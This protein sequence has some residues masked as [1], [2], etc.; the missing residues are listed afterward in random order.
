MKKQELILKVTFLDEQVQY[1]SL[2]VVGEK[3][4]V[5]DKNGTELKTGDIVM[6]NFKDG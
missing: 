1:E 4:P 5:K 3:T 2:G 6:F